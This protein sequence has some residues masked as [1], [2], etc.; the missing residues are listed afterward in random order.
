MNDGSVEKRYYFE[1][2]LEIILGKSNKKRSVRKSSNGDQADDG[3][4][5]A[6]N[7]NDSGADVIT[8]Q[9]ADVLW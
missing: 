7:N 2:D 9:S 3:T 4:N 1:T 6:T 8:P 5:V